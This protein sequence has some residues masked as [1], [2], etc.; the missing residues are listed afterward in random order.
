MATKKTNGATKKPSTKK[1]DALLEGMK[2]LDGFISSTTGAGIVGTDKFTSYSFSRRAD[3][4]NTTLENLYTDNDIAATIVERIVKDAL[5]AGYSLDW[6]GAD[7]VLV[8]ATVDWAEAKYS[9][10]S[11]VERSR[12]YARLFG[13]GASFI[14]ADDGLPMD[15]PMLEGAPI[16]FL[17]P[18]SSPDLLP[19]Q[20][21]IDPAE[22]NFGRVAVYTLS[23][24][25]FGKGSK[26][27]RTDVDHSRLVEF[28][29]VL[30]T[31]K[32]FQKT[33]WG[34]SVLR[35]VYDVL[36][37][38][39]TSFDSIQHS[40]TESSVPVYKVEGLLNMLASQN[41][42]LLQSRFSLI[43]AGKSNF[44]AIVLGENESY[45]RVAAQLQEAANVVE[46]AMLRVAGAAQMPATILF[47]RSPAGMNSTGQS[48]MEVWYQSVAQEQS[49]VLGPAIRK[50]YSILLAQPDSPTNGEVPADLKV[51]FPPLWTPSLQEQTNL[52]AQRAGADI[53]YVQAGVLKPEEVAVARAQEPGQFPK[54]DIMPRQE[55]LELSATPEAVLPELP[56][57]ER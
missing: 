37:K 33:G 41:R 32:N 16:E 50:L 2:K 55:A 56:E 6:Q 48:D 11:T 45:E 36:L 39:E 49:L 17:R 52:Y 22:Q 42:E 20:W 5:R 38:F 15:Q 21:Y 43:N 29:G 27:I 40:L 18:I 28:Y 51:I 57:E 1:A 8:R 30:T 35:R 25:N 3:L 7:D 4:D 26:Q 9:V 19:K 44:R 46:A 24:P 23:S 31:D 12:I 14:G 47:G 13:G 34:E 54:V 53:G 10:T